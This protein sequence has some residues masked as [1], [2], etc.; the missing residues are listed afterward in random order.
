MLPRQITHQNIFRVLIAGFSLVI[1]LLLA[2]AVVGVRN[3]RAIQQNAAVIWIYYFR[4]DQDFEVRDCG[5]RSLRIMALK[6]RIAWANYL[7]RIGL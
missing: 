7:P 5:N 3:I 2:A 1:L 4:Y 6:I